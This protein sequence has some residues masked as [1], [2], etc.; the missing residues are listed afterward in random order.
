MTIADLA[1][2]LS[3]LE[4]REVRLLVWGVVDGGF[5]PAELEA[6][7]VDFLAARGVGG[8]ADALLAAM[9]THGLLFRL[10]LHGRIVY[11]TRL[12]EGVRLL[13]RL[14]Q[15]FPGKP[16]ETA[17]SLVADYRLSVRPRA[18]P[19]PGPAAADV[20]DGAARTVPSLPPAARAALSALLADARRPTLADFQQRACLR[21]LAD[22]Q[23]QQRA[24][25][26]T[27]VSA[28][29]GTGK[30]LAFYL[31][32]LSHVA[33]LMAATVGKRWTKV[34]ALYPRNELLKDQFVEA[35]RETRKLDAVCR[36][37]GRRKM[38]VAAYFGPTPFAAERRYL[39]DERSAWRRRGRDY[40][41]PFLSCPRCGGPVLW[42][43]ADL[44]AGVERLRC[45]AAGCGAAIDGDEVPLTRLSIQ[46]NPPDVLF[47]TTET[48]NRQMSSGYARHVFGVGADRS[49]ELVLLD[50]AHTY[51]GTHGAQVA[52]LLRR[53][54]RAV[55]GHARVV[56]VGLSA[57][58]R[59]APQFFADLTGLPRSAVAEVS[60]AAELQR[61]GAE[62]QLALRG[63]PVSATSLLSTT[64]QSAMLLRRLLDPFPDRGATPV[65]A[66]LYGQRL[67]VFTDDLDVNNRLFHNLLDAE[68]RDSWG[69]GVAGQ[70]TLAAL[71]A[72]AA[73]DA[74]ARLAAGQSWRA[75]EDVHHD[76]ARKLK[77]ERVS[78]QD[79]GLSPDADV[80]VATST[81]EVGY[82]DQTC[83][84][85]V[86]HKAPRG[87]ASFLQRKGRAGRHRLMRPWTVVV[88]SDYGRD[89]LAYQGYDQLFDPALKPRTLPL[90]NRYVLRMQA[91][92]A[93]LDWLSTKLPDRLTDGAVWTDAT[94]PRDARTPR[95]AA[96][97]DVLRRVL[98]GR[99]HYRDELA[100]YLGEALAV[101]PA[102]VRSLLWE[103]PRPVLTGAVPTL[104]RRLESNWHR[105]RDAEAEPAVDLV[106]DAPLPD[107]VPPNLF[108]DLN[109]PEVEVIA[110]RDFPDAARP[111]V[112]AEHHWMPLVQAIRTFAPGRV[113]R[114]YGTRHARLNH[115]FPPPV[116]TGGLQSV[117]AADYCAEYDDLGDFHVRDGEAVVAVRCLRPWRVR[118][119]R[120]PAA[121]LP[122]SNAQLVWRSQL[123]PRD[124]GFDAPLPAASPWAAV[125]TGAR[126]FLH[127]RGSHVH[128]RR[129][130][131]GSD[132]TVR[133][134]DGTEHHTAVRFTR[135]GPGG[136]TGPAAVGFG[137]DVDGLAFA[138]RLPAGPVLPADAANADAV[139]RFRTAWFRHRVLTDPALSAGTNAFQRDWLAQVFLSAVT[140]H[141]LAAGTGLAA[142][143]ADL[144]AG[145][146]AAELGRVLEAIFQTLPAT[147]DDADD[148]GPDD[149]E[150]GDVAGGGGGDDDGPAGDAQPFVQRVHGVLLGLFADEAVRRRLVELSAVLHEPPDAAW[151]AWAADRFHATLG[152]A[153]LGGCRRL[154]PQ[155]ADG[156]LLL[157]LDAGPAS[158]DSSSPSSS[159][160]RAVW[161]TEST[162]GGGGV[163]EELLRRYAE[164]PRRFFLLVE[165]ELAASDFERID[166]ELRRLLGWLAD[167][168]VDVS[169]AVEAAREAQTNAARHAAQGQLLATLDRRGLVV[170]HAVMA[171]VNARVLRPSASPATDALL[172]RLAD[173]WALAEAA[174]GVEVDARVFAYVATA[175][176]D[177]TEAIREAVPDGDADDPFWRFT[178]LAGLLWPRGNVVRARSLQSYN[179]FATPPDADRGLVLDV[180]R[181]GG[182]AIPLDADGAWR[183][184]VAVALAAAGEVR[185][186]CGAGDAG[187]LHAA[188]LELTT[189]P[190]P[191][192]FL[193]V[194]PRLEGVSRGADG[195]VGHLRLAEAVQ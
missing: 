137:E 22:L 177:L 63:D 165:A 151:D 52:L 192:G 90:S 29:T 181:P 57:T 91:V 28:G 89:R 150:D 26:G 143:V 74:A 53:W 72:T 38:S 180:V 84:A 34:L 104:L 62:Y 3:V 106:G 36:Q 109:L 140:A 175:D 174:L 59:E 166:A 67:F 64:I 15:L 24:S 147:A 86:Q 76:L 124:G 4:A 82:N 80:A 92:Y 33:G 158:D 189:V 182:A 23:P 97:A 47:T 101:G 168:E 66:G 138:I 12:A 188:V 42:A 186:T 60:P 127:A 37:H 30:T 114:R 183:T 162:P 153:L 11:R 129:F 169:D 14:R 71:R 27:V 56:Y 43:G 112:R 133:L 120:S 107:F 142:A 54:R 179:P 55:G 105:L 93:L 16:W 18:Y 65:A 122:T 10:N 94:R 69:Q 146:L 193:S 96:L 148:A 121:V 41:C 13:A 113:S 128:A 152:Q 25:R 134:R 7:A 5:A 32:A 108:S 58:L 130:A 61:E 103:R 195:I 185:I 115:W 149:G 118:V 184:T 49:P 141:A 2:F 135:P 70:P 50:E 95:Q 194:Y 73:P 100:A 35:Y 1:E 126:F 46:R 102:V 160:D 17:P 44:D 123:L 187:R 167:G 98:D 6:L 110:E 190:T 111:D 40:E 156:D 75:A 161:I 155:F 125:V 172:A 9:D 51:A 116:I 78:S 170:T 145:D 178:V 99:D 159:G 21:L 154:C 171:A 139:R 85:V 68:G 19:R 81:L 77:V 144:A 157:D 164:D 173:R 48:L 31:P 39:E 20:A 136:H 8:T 88:L 117:D 176:A 191:A 83:G 131:V 79:G 45:A 87:A 163:I 132:A 119:P